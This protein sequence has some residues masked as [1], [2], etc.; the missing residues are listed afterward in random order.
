MKFLRLGQ[1]RRDPDPAASMALLREVLDPPI[2]PGYHSAAQ[3]RVEAGLPASSGYRTWLLFAT[4]VALGLLVTV[5]AVT[6]RRPDPVAAETRQQLITR[7]E[8]VQEDGDATR[9]RVE[10]LRAQILAIEQERARVEEG[11]AAERAVASAGMQAGAL[12]VTGPGVVVT[13]EDAADV[14][15]APGLDGPPERVNARDVQL[16]VNGLWSAGA[17][18]VSVN[19]HRLTT[20]SAIRFAGEAIIVDFRSL[21]PPYEIRAI[22]DPERLAAETSSGVTG[23]Y[24]GELRS[25]L[26]ITSR[27]SVQDDVTISAAER[28][29]TRYGHVLDETTEEDRR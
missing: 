12:A 6:L 18:A 3:A 19:G 16:V 2:G 24:L 15:E 1:A 22:G 10:E 21:A 9:T 13:L 7:I 4:A 28:L 27:V 17:E 8:A 5:S 26:G 25:Q 29:T 11:P 23:A 20:T 14:G